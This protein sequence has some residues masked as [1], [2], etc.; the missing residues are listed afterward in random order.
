MA[1]SVFDSEASPSSTSSFSATL[2]SSS[3]EIKNCDKLKGV[4]F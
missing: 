1:E 4:S 3:K 2:T